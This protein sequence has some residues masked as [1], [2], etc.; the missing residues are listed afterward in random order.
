MNILIAPNAFKGSLSSP[1]AAKA[2]A[3][4]AG[5]AAPTA[6]ITLIP[7]ADGGDGLID[8]LSPYKRKTV[9]VAVR[10]PD[11]KPV[12][13]DYLVLKDGSAVIETARACGLA[14][15]KGKKLTPMTATSYGAG[16]LI[17]DALKRGIRKIYIGLGGSATN[18][19]GAGLASALGAKLSDKKGRQIPP[20]I[21][22][23]LHLATIDT[24]GLNPLL[25]KAKLYAL[26]DV[27][28]PLLGKTGSARVYGPQKGATPAQ[29]GI[30]DKALRH[31][32]HVLKK[33]TGLSVGPMPRA[34]ASGAMA[35]GLFALCGASL[36]DG[37]S[38]TL[39]LL[40]FDKAAKSADIIIT[41][42]GCFDS[43]TFYG[44]APAAVAT[45]GKKY[46]KPVFIIAGQ[47]RAITVKHLA[48][49]GISAAWCLCGADISPQ[50]AQKK[51][52]ALVEAAAYY[53]VREITGSL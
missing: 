50:T 27:T 37:A 17:A 4:G 36:E 24:S 39:N 7:V 13:A 49:A 42:E 8:S 40:D 22:G 41:G 43:Q 20:G 48:D 5:N 33:C 30:M 14:L 46:G 2:M 44:K 3:R 21:E 15:M 34:G 28:N 51:A 29:V 12:K 1:D 52:A 11:A 35:T 26:T 18:D 47:S 23:L 31:Y 16:E 38:F 53:L 9:T 32:A 25:K 10:G 45:V 19:G 6:R